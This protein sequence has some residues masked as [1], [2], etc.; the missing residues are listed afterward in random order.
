[1]PPPTRV[2]VWL[3]D[4]LL[5][6]VAI[7]GGS[8]EDSALYETYKERI[9]GIIRL[10]VLKSYF[11]SDVAGMITSK[12]TFEEAIKST[13]IMQAQ[14]LSQVRRTIWEQLAPVMGHGS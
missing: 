8:F 12:K 6:P 14:R 7:G 4:F 5:G 3:N 9:V 10:P 1:M 2:V 13:T 11:R